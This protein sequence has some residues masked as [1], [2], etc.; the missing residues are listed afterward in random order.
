[1]NKSDLGLLIPGTR[2]QVGS[3]W[4]GSELYGGGDPDDGD[5]EWNAILDSVVTVKK[6]QIKFD[7]IEVYIE[8][9]DNGY[10]YIEEIDHVVD[11]VMDDTLD[12]EQSDVPL[13]IL[14]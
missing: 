8:E 2:V 4:L 7:R 1:M 11:S 6:V 12:L 5:A 14:Y 3:R 9:I 13:S 10:V